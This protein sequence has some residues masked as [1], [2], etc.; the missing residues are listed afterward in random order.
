MKER[1]QKLETTA[2]GSQHKGACRKMDDIYVMD[3][4]CKQLLRNAA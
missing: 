3:E 2:A 1:F 4:V